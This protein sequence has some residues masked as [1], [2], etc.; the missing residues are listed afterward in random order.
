ME[1]ERRTERMLSSSLPEEMR[2]RR[3]T[4]L[5]GF[6][7]SFVGPVAGLLTHDDG[8]SMEAEI[9]ELNAAKSNTSHMVGQQTHIVRAQL[10]EIHQLT[11]I[12]DSIL[13]RHENRLSELVIGFNNLTQEMAKIA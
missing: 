12:H 10:E 11:K 3:A 13:S 4:P 6:I 7:G 5:L 8:K 1:M 2:R 9:N